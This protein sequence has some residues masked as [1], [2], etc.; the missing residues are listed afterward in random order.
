MREK[1]DE[2]AQTEGKHQTE[3]WYRDVGKPTDGRGS[4]GLGD[5]CQVPRTVLHR[6]FD[7]R[8]CGGDGKICN[9]HLW[10]GEEKE[11]FPIVDDKIK[12]TFDFAQDVT[13][14]LITLST[15]I[16]TLTITF[17]TEYATPV[18][19]LA[20]ILAVLGW[21]AFLLSTL[22]GVWVL[23]AL[24]GTLEPRQGEVPMS[25]R[26]S[27]VTIPSV[28]QVFSFLAGLLLTVVFGAVAL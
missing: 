28:L 20:R 24:T 17:G 11:L 23:M 4:S 21:G 10:R 14:Q 2:K 15:A 19:N 18:G 7:T 6:K 9:I 22:F 26:G 8:T 16:I 27:N 13:K 3:Q 25:I 1:K 5:D 12:M